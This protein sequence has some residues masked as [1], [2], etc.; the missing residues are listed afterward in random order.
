MEK[1]N[2]SLDAGVQ[3][4]QDRVK[5]V[6]VEKEALAQPAFQSSLFVS[7]LRCTSKLGQVSKQVTT[8]TNPSVISPRRR[9]IAPL[10]L[11]SPGWRPGASLCVPP[12]PPGPAK[13]ASVSCSP[14]ARASKVVQPYLATAQVAFHSLLVADRTPASAEHQAVKPGKNSGDLIPEF[15]DKLVHGVSRRISVTFGHSSSAVARSPCGA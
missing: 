2:Q 12:S 3:E 1:G 13:L 15:R 7:R 8:H 10:S 9:S 5:R 11:S 14:R 6:V 4:A